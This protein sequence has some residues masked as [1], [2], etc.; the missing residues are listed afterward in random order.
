MT[1]PPDK[2]QAPRT[3]A[4]ADLRTLENDLTAK[5]NQVKR[6]GTWQK[7]A[8]YFTAY[9][10][11]TAGAVTGGAALIG[12]TGISAETAAAV[13]LFGSVA[14]ALA[15][16]V[17]LGGKSVANRDLAIDY[18]TLAEDA[19]RAARKLKGKAAGDAYDKILRDR[20][21]LR[22]KHLERQK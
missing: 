19:R 12:E 1:D 22:K 5:A 3:N 4:G 10:G 11:A 2:T 16:A 21:A 8:S 7:N 14:A 9:G 6:K 15:S 20:S 13:L 18:E 17:N